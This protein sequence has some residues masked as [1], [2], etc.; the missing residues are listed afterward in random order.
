[1]RY[2]T[3]DEWPTYQGNPFPAPLRATLPWSFALEALAPNNPLKELDD[4]LKPAAQA[5]DKPLDAMLRQAGISAAAIKFGVGENQA[6]GQAPDRVSALHHLQLITWATHMSRREGLFHIVGGNQRMPE[7]MAAALKEPVKLGTPVSAV[8]DR[9]DS[10]VI[11][12]PDGSF[13][14]KR[15]LITLPA[16]ALRRIKLTPELPPAQRRGIDELTYST[17]TQ[18]L[19]RIDEP[20]WEQDGL[21][22]TLWTDTEIGQL[23]AFPYGPGGATQSAAVWLMGVDA[24][25]A[26]KLTSAALVE[27]SMTVLRRIRPKAAKALTPI[28]VFSWQKERYTGGTW[29]SWAPGQI[30]AFAN[31]IGQRHGRIHFCGE[32]TARLDRGMEGAMES[33]DRVILEILERML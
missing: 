18:V 12:T 26:D 28:K 6:Y 24:L 14:A 21:P 29:A 15:A 25:E 27:R 32:H 31:Q 11:E 4:W 13:E 22:P 23:L 7:A 20:Y 30:G 10:V 3:V 33:A 19:F 2:V 16:P 8:H 1:G 9:G 5:Y 17:T